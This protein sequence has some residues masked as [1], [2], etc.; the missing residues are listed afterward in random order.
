MLATTG[1]TPIA[2]TAPTAHETI[3]WNH[4]LQAMAALNSIRRVVLAGS[5]FVACLPA[6]AVLAAPAGMA[7][8]PTCRELERR[9]DLVR[10]E[11]NSTGLNLLLFAAADAGCVPLTRRL[12]DVGAS[13]VA[14]DRLGAMAL[15]RAARAGHVALVELFLAQ[16]APIDARN[17]VGA[18]ALYAA[19]ENERQTTV[20]VLLARHADPNLPGPSGVTPLAAA[21][22]KGNGRIVDQLITNGADPNVM[23]TTGKAAMTYAAGR[24]FALIVRRLLEAGVDPRRAYG[25][26]LTALMW[27]AGSEDGVGARAAMDVVEMLLVA[28]APIDAIDNRGR[29]ALMIAAELGHAEIVDLL[30][31]RGADRSIADKSG[32]RARDLAANQ[33]IRE[34]LEAK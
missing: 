20:A 5:I 28:G 13:L 27:A 25:N 16:G 17:L 12:L 11:A 4:V 7:A 31:G 18:T 9:L 26:D 10:P 1:P 19:A 14:R 34:K 33:S 24:G 15:A 29:T 8:G 23:D 21:A 32:K 22:F 2:W 6:Q 30:L 3:A